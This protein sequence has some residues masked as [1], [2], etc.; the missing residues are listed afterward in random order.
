M[1]ILLIVLSLPL[2]MMLHELGHL[3]AARLCGVGASELG[4]GFGPRLFA[5]EIKKFRVSFRALPLGSFIRLDGASLSRRPLA[6]R[7]FVH[8][9]GA[10]VNLLLAAVTFGTFFGY[11]NLLLGLTNLLPIY[12]HDGW[13][14]GVALMRA[15]LRKESRPVEW[16]FTFSG[17]FASIAMVYYLVQHLF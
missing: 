14:C 3:A 1:R 10:L 8:S 6:E 7:L 4:M 9:A 16:V 15:L 13:K 11:I 17:C 2:S 12:Q 5:F